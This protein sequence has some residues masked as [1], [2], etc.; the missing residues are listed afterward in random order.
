MTTKPTALPEPNHQ[1]LREDYFTQQQ[2]ID[3]GR[4]EYL[5]GLEDAAIVADTYTRWSSNGLVGEAIR[6]LAKEQ[7]T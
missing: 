3:Y 4:A 6:E 7:Q 2:L 5:R 1:G